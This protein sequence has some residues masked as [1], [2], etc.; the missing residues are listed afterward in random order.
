MS[1]VFWC[2]CVICLS[3]CNC[4]TMVDSMYNV[5]SGFDGTDI[6][7]SVYYFFI[8]FHHDNIRWRLGRSWYSRGIQQVDTNLESKDVDNYQIL[9]YFLLNLR[10]WAAGNF[11][12]G[13]FLSV[14]YLSQILDTFH[15]FTFQ[16]AALFWPLVQTVNYYFILERNRVPFI[17]VCSLGWTVFLAVVKYQQE[18]ANRLTAEKDEI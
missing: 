2:L 13:L 14:P 5:F 8:L 7:F 18:K 6:I 16:V 17:G 3:R 11:R 10:L 9:Y 12:F 4:V 15:I 1:S